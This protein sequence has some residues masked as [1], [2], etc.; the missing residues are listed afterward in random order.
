MI[1]WGNLLPTGLANYPNLDR[2]YHH[3]CEDGGVKRA[4]EQQQIS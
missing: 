4:M 2:F 3:W 1:R